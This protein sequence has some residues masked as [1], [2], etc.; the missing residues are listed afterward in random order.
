MR[1]T[2][3]AVAGLALTLMLVGAETATAT[4]SAQAATTTPAKR[5][6]AA[7]SA[8]N[9]NPD[10]FCGDFKAFYFFGGTEQVVLWSIGTPIRTPSGYAV[11]KTY[12]HTYDLWV[13][14]PYGSWPTT[15]FETHWCP[16]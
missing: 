14:D 10:T 4:G 6:P 8:L 5:A 1:R 9:G 11:R 7:V 12:Y 16:W 13:G 15:W 2:K 3:K